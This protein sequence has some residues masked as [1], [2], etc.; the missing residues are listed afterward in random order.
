MPLEDILTTIRNRA[1]ETAKEILEDAGLRAKRRIDAVRAEAQ[2]RAAGILSVAEGEA[3]KVEGAAKTRAG[4][5]QRQAI[6]REKQSLIEGV[7]AEAREALATL[8]AAEYK[9][10][11]LESLSRSAEGHETV[12]LGPEDRERLGPDFA[13]ELKDRLSSL[14]KGTG[15]KVEFAEKSLGGGYIL[16]SGGVSL[17]STFPALVRR[18]EDELEIEVAR[19]LFGKRE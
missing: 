10:L 3:A 14:G 4:A 15:V 11:I 16:R 1:E 12:V 9:E 2:E 18:F 8:P 5:G 6:L 17:D 7:F 19:T 13:G